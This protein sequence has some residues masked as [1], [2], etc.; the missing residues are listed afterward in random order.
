MSAQVSITQL[1]AA[2]ALTGTEAV[3]IVQNGVTVQTTTG[4]IAV[5]PTQTQT[6]LTATQQLSLTNSRYLTTGTG[7]SYTDNGSG[8]YFQVALNGAALSLE[9]AAGGIIVKDSASTVV[10]RSIVASGAGISVANGDG[11]G[12]NPTVSLT[13]LPLTLANLS[14]SGML[15]ILNGTSINNKRIPLLKKVIGSNRKINK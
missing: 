8:S 3:P 9:S 1:P 7:I 10:A 6:F 12:D 15:A 14:G 4:A 5:Q 11:T 13:G 2:T